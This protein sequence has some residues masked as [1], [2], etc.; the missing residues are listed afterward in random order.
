MCAN[1]RESAYEYSVSFTK[2]LIAFGA[3]TTDHTHSHLCPNQLWAF[4]KLPASLEPLERE[5][6]RFLSSCA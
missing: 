1:F 3:G 5:W 6:N 2:E 4:R